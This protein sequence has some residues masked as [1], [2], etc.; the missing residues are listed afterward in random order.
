MSRVGG[1]TTSDVRVI[2]VTDGVH[3][4]ELPVTVLAGAGGY[5][6]RVD[7]PGAPG[8]GTHQ[9]YAFTAA[10]VG[11]AAAVTRDAPSSWAAPHDGELL[12]ISHA[13][14][15]DA[16]APLV[17][18]RMQ[19]GWT[20][21]I[22]DVQDVYDEQG[23]GDKS[24]AAIRAFIQRARASWRVPPRFVLFVGDATFDPRNFMGKGDF[25]FVPTRLIDT[26]AMETAS[27]DWFVDDDLDGV[28]EIAIGRLPVRTGAQASAI[29]GKLLGYAGKA[30]LSRG[31]LF[32]TDTDDVDLDFSGA[33]TAGRGEGVGHHA[34]RSLPARHQRDAGRAAR[35]AGRG[36]VPG[37]LPRPRFGRGLGRLADDEPRPPP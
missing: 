24:P 7:A 30:D 17:A 19:E 37:E 3:P 4:V 1:F 14:F 15:M 29:V 21:Q 20:V 16:L 18:R 32:V 11:A 2:D 26:A 33:S 27:D 22:A 36:A 9:L 5:V 12:I 23:F 35:E 8:D 13:A 34:D 6:A 31:G 10:K 25:D 28:P